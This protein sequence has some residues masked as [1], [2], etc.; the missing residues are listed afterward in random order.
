MAAIRDFA[1][2][3][4]AIDSIVLSPECRPSSGNFNCFILNIVNQHKQIILCATVTLC[5]IFSSTSTANKSRPIFPKPPKHLCT[6]PDRICDF[7]PDCAEAED[8]SKCGEFTYAVHCF[9]CFYEYVS[10]VQ[11]TLEAICCYST[12]N[13]KVDQVLKSLFPDKPFSCLYK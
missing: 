6:E 9:Y 5:I 10:A 8:E 3:G 11:M 13:Y 2:G 1:Y 12:N 7:N 4:I